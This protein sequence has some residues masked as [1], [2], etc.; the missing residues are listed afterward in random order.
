MLDVSHIVWNVYL[1][2]LPVGLS[3]IIAIVYRW[4]P[5]IRK[6][7][8]IWPPLVILWLGF[9]PNA[10]YLI[11]EWRHF[12]DLISRD[13]DMIRSGMR[14]KQ[15]LLDFLGL[16]TFYVIYSGTGLLTFSMSI[17]PLAQITRPRWWAKLVFFLLC[18]LGVYLGLIK[19]LN[20]WNLWTRPIAVLH[21]SLD[22]LSHPV[23]LLLI[24]GLAAALWLNYWVFEVFVDGLML[25]L[26]NLGYLGARKSP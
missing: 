1:A 20:T 16:A 9:L 12:I 19:R 8:W 4:F 25:R 15:T 21:Y 22:A 14:D 10:A 2:F 11:T 3:A 24:I 23:L 13:P 26:R 6:V 5:N 18:A 7:W 17:W